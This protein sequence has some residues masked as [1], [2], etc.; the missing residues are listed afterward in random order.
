MSVLFLVF[1]KENFVEYK[2]I[3]YT[4]DYV[5]NCKSDTVDPDVSRTTK[6]EWSEIK[7]NDYDEKHQCERRSFLGEYK[8]DDK[9]LPR[10]VKAIDINNNQFVLLNS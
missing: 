3:A 6:K 1:L 10:Y 4:D 5:F 8:F 2:P 9:G 7:F